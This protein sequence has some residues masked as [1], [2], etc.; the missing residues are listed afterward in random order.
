M[1]LKKEPLASFL[2]GTHIVSSYVPFSM[3]F[4]MM[5]EEMEKHDFSL[6]L[7]GLVLAVF[8]LPT[9]FF[10][11]CFNRIIHRYGRRCI[12]LVGLYVITLGA[13][14]FALL[15]FINSKVG[16]MIVAIV[17]RLIMGYGMFHTKTIIF[18]ISSK[19][20]PRSV[21]GIYT[22]IYIAM[23]VAVGIGPLLG[24][25]IYNSL[26]SF[27]WPIFIVISINLA[28][29]VPIAHIVF[30]AKGESISNSFAVQRVNSAVSA[31]SGE[32]G[33]G[34]VRRQSS[35]LSRK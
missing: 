31:Q 2:I 16:F 1:C 9:L 30:P 15:E 7:T 26:D 10:A 25:A 29:F 20:F 17:G 18:P 14:V 23:N 4:P 5:P 32:S 24:N 13:L 3:V 34:D 12:Y 8:S 27:F 28:I 35:R 21:D 22:I 19:R 11:L 6:A 33:S